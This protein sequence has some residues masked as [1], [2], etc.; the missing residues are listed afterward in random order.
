MTA[1]LTPGVYYERVDS[2]A[3]G[4]IGVR[5]DIAGFVGIAARGPVDTAV[6]LQSYR[7]FQSYFGDFTGAGYLAYSVRAF[8]ENGGRR[9]WAVRVA[10]D[11]VDTASVT[12]QD[13]SGSDVW[14]VAAYSA[15]SWGNALTV[16]VTETHSGQTAS[17]PAVSTSDVTAVQSITGFGIASLVQCS[18]PGAPDQWRVVVSID[19]VLGTIA[20]VN[21]NPRLRQPYEQPLSGFDPNVP[22]QL[23]SVEYT[24]L[25]LQGAIPV[26][27]YEGLSL[28][29]ASPLYGASILAPV[30]VPTGADPTITL[31]PSPQAIVITE[32]RA[33][34]PLPPATILPLAASPD[35]PLQLSGGADGLAALDTYAFIGQEDDPNQ[36][37]AVRQRMRRGMRAIETISEIGI[38]A[39]PDICIQ[40]E[41]PPLFA[42]PPPCI[43]N[44]CLPMP[45][46]PARVAPLAQPAELPPIFSDDEIYQVQSALIAM[47]ESLGDRI[48]LLDPPWSTAQSPSVGTGAITAWRAR[49]DTSYAALYFPWLSVVDPLQVNPTRPI[50]PSGHVAGQC[51]ATDLAIGVFKAPAN[52]PLTW[53]QD[54]TVPVDN[55]LHGVL[56]PIGVN[57]IRPLG[58]RGIRIYGARTVSSNA[59]WLYVNVRRLL[60]MIEKSIRLAVQWAV[61]APND[62]LTWIKI[63]LAL[64]SFFTVLWQRG[65][66]V[67]TTV[68]QAFFVKCDADTNPP[69]Q[70]DNGQL[71]AL[72][73]VA[74]TTPFEFV[75]VRIGRTDN[76]FEVTTTSTLLGAA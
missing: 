11:G 48:A 42:P 14:N 29:P 26:A 46:L 19:P 2:S 41:Q 9:C 49:F 15:G 64:T 34:A 12:L 16:L 54:V 27:I 58:G 37:D 20:W 23:E 75:V 67:G 35:A 76:Q 53:L 43:P 31:P 39:V 70:V 36:S 51:A 69:A 3:P 71:V 4:I 40:P 38:V 56:N 30:L 52:A 6:P 66:L 10:G 57:A 45:N 32:L 25:V 28:L 50:P 7:Q 62:D 5:T 47:C 8:F 55:A 1:Y 60:M 72:A 13:V 18:Q 74:P 44:V 61:F 59:A 73:G 63:R 22:I 21:P 68:D 65:A 17:I 33:F 24:L